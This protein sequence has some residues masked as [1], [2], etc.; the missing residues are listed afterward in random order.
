ML[1][2]FDTF[3]LDDERFQLTDADGRIV[4]L[5]PRALELLLLLVRHATLL[6]TKEM[7]VQEVWGGLHVSQKAISFQLNA[8][9]A[10][11]GDDGKPHRFIQTVHGK[12]LRFVG[13]V[14]TAKSESWAPA[15]PMTFDETV[16]SDDVE[17]DLIGDQPTIAVLPFREA[18]TEDH[19]S[20]L[21]TAL[22]GDILT[23]LSQLRI[24]R[25]TARSSTFQVQANQGSPALLKSAFGADYGV[26]GSVSRAGENYE[27]FV[28]LTDNASQSIVWANQ[29]EVDPRDIHDLRN[30]LAGQI[31]QHIE[32]EIPRH[33]ANRIRLKPPESLTAWQA[34]HK[35][36]TLAYTGSLSH[37]M[38]ARRF[39][40]RVVAIDPSFAR[41]WAGLAQTY[42]FDVFRYSKHQ[43]K[44]SDK[45][46]LK[47]AEKAIEADPDD[48]AANLWLGRAH[49]TVDMEQSGLSWLKR[50]TE[51]APSYALAHR[52][53]G[54]EYGRSREGRKAIEHAYVGLR[55]DPQG[56]ERFS[57]YGE[58]SALRLQQGDLRGALDF[59]FKAG[60][61]PHDEIQ[62]LLVALSA[63]H[64]GG[65]P[66][67]ARRLA[68]RFKRA[69]PSVEWDQVYGQNIL[70]PTTRG[71]VGAILTEYGID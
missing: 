69:F 49:S 53:L 9:R 71:L 26:E 18:R 35:G 22:P 48:P 32:R 70:D 17:T 1:Y 29:F 39:F 30:S 47:S 42:A 37:M 24:L 28:E 3:T 34:Y 11:L 63:N 13:A 60:E 36:A 7:I 25:V 33:E 40:Q 57:A 59:G 19:L 38:Q 43:G 56:P 31:V 15:Q 16:P 50:A 45:L 20:G 44:G 54:W 14:V 62:T 66:K 67:E 65:R 61:T 68:E 4:P 23:A 55:L 51:L 52:H 12:G 2:Q 41:G 8:L 64:H 6:V 5:Q 27:I 46:F 21:A 10:A 58:M